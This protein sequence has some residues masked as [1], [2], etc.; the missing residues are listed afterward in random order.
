MCNISASTLLSTASSVYELTQSTQSPKYLSKEMQRKLLFQIVLEKASE[1]IRQII[2]FSEEIN[3]LLKQSNIVKNTLNIVE[4]YVSPSL[5]VAVKDNILDNTSQ[6]IQV[7][8]KINQL[9]LTI[10]FLCPDVFNAFEKK[11]GLQ[12]KKSLNKVTCIYDFEPGINDFIFNFLSFKIKTF[13]FEALDCILSVNEMPIKTHLFYNLSK[14]HIVGFN[15]SKSN[16]TYTP[17]KHALVL[18]IKAINHNWMQ[19]IAYYLMSE[20]CLP[21]NLS[22]IICLIIR[23]LKQININVKAL[24]TH[25]N[26][27]FLSFSKLKCVSP[28]NPYFKVDGE[29]IVYIFDPPNLL[30]ATLKIFFKHN[31]QINDDF[32]DKKHLETFYNFDSNCYLRTAPKLMHEHVYPGSFKK[33]KIRFAAQI[34]SHSVAEGMSTVLDWGILPTNSICTINFIKD[35]VKLFDIFN[36]SDKPNSNVFKLPFKNNSHQLDHLNKMTEMFKNMKVISKLNGSDMTQQINCLN[37]WLVSI[38]GLQMLWNSLNNNQN[39]DYSLCTGS[40]NQDCFKNLFGKYQQ[41]HNDN[42]NPTPILFISAFKKIFWGEYFKRSLDMK[43]FEHLSYALQKLNEMNKI[44]SAPISEIFNLNTITPDLTQSIFIFKPIKIGTVDYRQ[45]NIPETNALI[46]VCGYLM[47]KCLEKHSCIDCI[48]Y[49]KFQTKIELS[50]L[51]SFFYYSVND[52]STFETLMLLHD[53]FYNYIFKLE[54]L[55]VEHFSTF[56]TENN[57]GAK[58]RDILINT[59]LEHPCGNFNHEYLLNL[60]IRFRIFYSIK[61]LNKSFMS[62]KVNQ[63]R[64]LSILK[65]V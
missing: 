39:K 22:S 14:D 58:L 15:Q 18:M 24:V 62:E 23:R 51:L 10:Y 65:L 12:T 47:K 57:V 4:K 38:S 49:A 6:R 40:I 17:A 20:N 5:F 16:R 21:S 55:F 31:F 26:S 43:S 53:N 34:F 59:H 45:L 2:A 7:F 9:A 25:Q 33:M 61:F 63:N 42:T 46:Y 64:K 54:S 3:T 36:S 35:M 32:V 56:A 1:K 8:N 11:Y 48:S 19:P 29:K 27:N 50:F 28:D 44:T 41:N 60:F 52:N 13:P 37:G 30:K